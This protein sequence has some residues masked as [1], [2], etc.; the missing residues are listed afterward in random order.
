MISFGAIISAT[1]FRNSGNTHKG[2]TPHTYQDR[3]ADAGGQK[4]IRPNNS[5]HADKGKQ[6]KG[7]INCLLSNSEPRSEVFSAVAT[8]KP[9]PGPMRAGMEGFTPKIKP[10]SVS[11][12]SRTVGVL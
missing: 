6:E 8:T 12:S 3:D 4:F 11:H 1:F 2:S 5:T 7:V 10:F 9:P